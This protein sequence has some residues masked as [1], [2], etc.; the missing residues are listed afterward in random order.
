VQQVHKA[1]NFTAICL[2]DVGALT[3]HTSMN[4]HDLLQAQLVFLSFL[5][6]PTKYFQERKR[7]HEKYHDTSINKDYH[8]FQ[9]IMI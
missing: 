1:D 8:H 4:L 6:L 3:S 9:G 7:T 5:P 2:E